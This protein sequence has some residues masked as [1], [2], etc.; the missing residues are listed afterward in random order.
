MTQIFN[1]LRPLAIAKLALKPGDTVLDLAC[2][3]GL[4]FEYLEREVGLGGRIIGVEI[5]PD[6]L[7]LARERIE[8]HKWDNITL[9]ESTAEE[10][11]MPGPVDAVLCFFTP[12]IMSSRLALE[13]ALAALRPGGRIVVSG[14]KHAEG[15][16]GMPVTLFYMIRFRVWRFVNVKELVNRL[17]GTEQPYTILESMV[18]SLERRDYQRGC[19]YIAY[20]VK[21]ANASS[22]S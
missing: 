8:R 16:R 19:S 11:D 18:D 5:S 12:Q 3:S 1:E 13:R 4:S 6:M 17:W 9:I 22:G 7:A 21:G 2:G 20:A 14:V 15:V 10:V